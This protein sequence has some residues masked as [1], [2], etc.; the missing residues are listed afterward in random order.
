MQ[1]GGGQTAQSSAHVAQSSP[2][3]PSQ[4]PFPQHEPPTSLGQEADKPEHDSAKSQGPVAGLHTPPLAKLSPGHVAEAPVHDSA[5]SQSPAESLQMPLAKLSPGQ[6]A[7]APEHAS[8]TSHAPADARQ[9]PPLTKLSPGQAG[10][11]P[12]H[13]SGT[14]QGPADMRQTPLRTVSAGHPRETPVQ[15]SATSQSPETARQTVDEL[16]K[17][18]V[19]Q[20][21]LKPLHASAGSHSPPARHTLP[22]RKLLAGQ[23]SPPTQRSSASQVPDAVRQI[24]V[25]GRTASVGQLGP[26]PL[27][28]SATSQTPRAPRQ[29]LLESKRS[30]G[31][32][33]PPP[34]VS[35]TSQGPT[36]ARQGVAA[37][38]AP[39]ATQRVGP[40]A[41]APTSHGFPVEHG[42]PGVQADEHKPRPS[43][44][45]L[46]HAV[47]VITKASGVQ[48]AVPVVQRSATSHAPA[49]ARQTV[50]LVASPSG[51]HSGL[52]P[53]Q[54]SATSQ[55]PAAARQS[56]PAGRPAQSTAPQS[57][58]QV[59]L[60]QLSPMAQ[61]G[62]RSQRPATQ[63]AVSQAEG[64][65]VV[66]LQTGKQPVT[67]SAPGSVGTHA[68]PGH[69]ASLASFPHMPLLQASLVQLNASA[70]SA[71]PRHL[72]SN[73]STLPTSAAVNASGSLGRVTQPMPGTQSSLAAQRASFGRWKQA[74]EMHSLSTHGVVLMQLAD[75]VHSGRKHAASSPTM[76][77]GGTQR[78]PKHEVPVSQVTAAQLR[79]STTV[80]R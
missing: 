12:E 46:G 76:H 23:S 16:E 40:H 14:S 39:M 72:P 71:G 79:V 63:E 49:A 78:N 11:A 74:P 70:Q 51:G 27:Q 69:A 61:V 6:A 25:P 59:P 65:H 31:Q 68:L 48:S 5:T 53:S 7:E 1:A 50:A 64:T 58:A 38:A 60:Q 32:V 21:A 52:V 54:V 15:L 77:S 42:A 62:V 17:S 19:G 29:T 22:E 30:A 26:A 9:T 4:T 67:R 33:V 45:P 8:A 73:A 44:L 13:V 37:G 56:V 36:A 75:E 3:A 20:L 43:Q 57:R 2:S 34:H 80:T 47:P 10:D 35:C 28:A 18:S 41:N 24:C 66:A 55:T